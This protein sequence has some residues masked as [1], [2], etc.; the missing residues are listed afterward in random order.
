MT[1]WLLLNGYSG[2][3]MK[4]T[5]I[6]DEEKTGYL[7]HIYLDSELIATIYDITDRLKQPEY[8]FSCKY[9]PTPSET[10]KSVADAKHDLFLL[11]ENNTNIRL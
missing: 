8:K 9:K 2:F 10:Y 7:E 3:P 5:S 11:I 4:L 6:R 1:L